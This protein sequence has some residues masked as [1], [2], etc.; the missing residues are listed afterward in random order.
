MWPI[1]LKKQ[2]SLNYKNIRI[3]DTSTLA[4]KTALTVVENKIPSVS[5]LVKKTDYNTKVTEIEINLNLMHL[6]LYSRV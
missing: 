5:N 3:P 6:A 1:L 4:T 2:I